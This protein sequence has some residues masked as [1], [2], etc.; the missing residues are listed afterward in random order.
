MVSVARWLGRLG[1]GIAV[2]LTGLGCLGAAYVI[3]VG[4]VLG[5]CGDPFAL[6]RAVTT[7]Y[8]PLWSAI[9]PHPTAVHWFHCYACYCGLK[10]DKPV[11][12]SRP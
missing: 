7:F 3:S 6:P 9:K 5:Y 10:F 1:H 12:E 11:R 8:G 2:A 4:P